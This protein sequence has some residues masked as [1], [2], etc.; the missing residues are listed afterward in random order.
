[1]RRNSNLGR[2]HSP[3]EIE[4]KPSKRDI[5]ASPYMKMVAKPAAPVVNYLHGKRVLIEYSRGGKI[6]QPK[7]K[8]NILLQDKTGKEEECQKLFNTKYKFNI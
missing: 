7:I 2:A 8:E 6:K 1:M 3:I 4:I 5:S